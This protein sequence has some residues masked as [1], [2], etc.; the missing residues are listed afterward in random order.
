MRRCFLACVL[1]IAAIAALNAPAAAAPSRPDEF[2][3]LP[4]VQKWIFDY[5]RKPEPRQLPA[6]VQ[7]LSR[8]QAFREPDSA[9]IY[10]GFIAGVI[11]ANPAR[12]DALVRRM[13]PLPPEDHWA[14]IRAIAYSGL[15]GWRGLLIR[16]ADRMPDRK[17]MINKLVSGDLPVLSDVR[18]EE[19]PAF[20][21][22]M[23]NYLSPKRYFGPKEPA[24]RKLTF[25]GSP[26]LLD[27]LWGYYFATGA[28]EPLA[29]IIALLPW[30]KE[31]DSTD[32]LTVG[33]MAKY[34]L[35]T[36]ASRD[37]DILAVLKNEV[38]RQPEEVKPILT[39]VID[40]AETVE[41]AQLRKEA[42]AAI[43][44]LKRK[45]PASKRELSLL[46]QIGQGAVYVGCVAA[47]ALGQ[48]Q[49]GIPCVIGGA[50]GS[51]A[52]SIFNGQQ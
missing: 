14:V 19:K 30:S 42:L 13:F 25:D 34:T 21:D 16:H 18:I 48:V 39:D 11:A 37:A 4:A 8:L 9:G 31:K 7:A 38:P 44:D 27:V 2:T 10:I 26:E 15:P 23:K 28:R 41:T 22:N 24:R 47:S 20:L 3:G 43:E 1:A 36:N 50:A 51:A 32:K 46:G 45:G 12:A 17:V 52:L 6:V 49:V 29:R 40:N 33:N 35:A 5:R